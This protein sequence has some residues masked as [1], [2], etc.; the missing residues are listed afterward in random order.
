MDVVGQ[1]DTKPFCERSH[2]RHHNLV[3]HLGPLLASKWPPHIAGILWSP[4]YYL[5]NE[6]KRLVA[7][8]GQCPKRKHDENLLDRF[9]K[10]SVYLQARLLVLCRQELPQPS[11]CSSGAQGGMHTPRA[12]QSVRQD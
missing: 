3:G 11:P 2:A 9:S 5:L 12:L 7:I 1:P 8:L 4:G 6:L 10:K